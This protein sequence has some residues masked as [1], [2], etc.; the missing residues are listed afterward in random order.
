MFAL[1][2]NALSVEMFASTFRSRPGAHLDLIRSFASSQ[3]RSKFRRPEPTEAELLEMSKQLRHYYLT[4]HDPTAHRRRVEIQRVLDMKLKQ[5]RKDDPKFQQQERARW[6]AADRIRRAGE[7]QRNRD[8][9]G[10]WLRSIPEWQRNAYDWKTHVPVVFPEAQRITCNVCPGS[11]HK[12]KLWWEPRESHSVPE[13]SDAKQWT[14]H[15]CYMKQEVTDILP[16]G[17]EN[18]VIGSGKRWPLP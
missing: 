2:K 14:C 13:T 10:S 4:R 16:K 3:T 7:G 18:H 8:S 12:A 17:L 9:F 6:R 1:L 11:P 15:S 5:R